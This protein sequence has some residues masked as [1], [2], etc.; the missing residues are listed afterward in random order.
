MENTRITYAYQGDTDYIHLSLMTKHYSRA[1]GSSLPPPMVSKH[2]VSPQ[3]L[4]VRWARNIGPISGP[5]PP[6][7]SD[8][9]AGVS[10]RTCHICAAQVGNQQVCVLGVVSGS[11]GREYLHPL[12][13]NKDV[14]VISDCSP[15]L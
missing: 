3:H 2:S 15:S 10:L 13:V 14:T 5:F 11:V 8:S 12:S 4:T 1:A 9:G 7:V 6:F